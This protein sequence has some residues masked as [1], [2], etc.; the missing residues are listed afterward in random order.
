[1]KKFEKRIAILQTQS[2]DH[3]HQFTLTKVRLEAANEELAKVAEQ[4][5]ETLEQ[6]KAAYEAKVAALKAAKEQAITQLADN[7]G[8]IKGINRL[9]N[10]GI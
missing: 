6:E 7:E 1:M 5:D 10:G 4:I 2:N 9:L 8:A 3:L